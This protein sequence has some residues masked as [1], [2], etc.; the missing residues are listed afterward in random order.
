MPSARGAVA[1]GITLAVFLGGVGLL[2]FSDTVHPIDALLGRGPMVTMPD[3]LG[4]ARPRAEAELRSLDLEVEVEY[5]YNLSA[6][7]G[8]IAETDPAAG[9]RIRA[10]ST[11]TIVVSRG[12]NRVEMPDAIG[13][14]LDEVRRPFDE[15][16]VP[17]EIAEI[18]DEYIPA[19]VVIGQSPAPG[20]M[21]TGRDQV[22]FIIS[23]GPEDRAVPDVGGMSAEGAGFTLGEAGLDLDEVE[24]RHDPSAPIGV[25]IGTEPGAG[26]VVPAGS[27][28]KLVIS[29][30]P[31][32][33]E[34]PDL[35][36]LTRERAAERL[37]ANG[38][39]VSVASRLVGPDG[40]GLGV[41]LDQFPPADTE[42]RPGLPVTIV[43]GR[44]LPT[45]PPPPPTTTT[46]TTLPEPTTTT[47]P[48]TTVPELDDE[49]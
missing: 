25:A 5:A 44:R 49:P 33:R 35:V 3:L 8:S 34:V 39:V 29:A 42:W 30:G 36:N 28:I 9:T 40:R 32:P 15:A 46:T 18:A 11:V 24:L 45:P 14:P 20:T 47:V 37:R 7:R 16:D 27:P 41:V 26:V 4:D 38:F 19:G 10:G 23:S 31:P 22:A 43:V 48:T 17:L 12:A 6:P 13:E 1:L 2:G 21:V